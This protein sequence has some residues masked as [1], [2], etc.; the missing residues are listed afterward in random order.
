MPLHTMCSLTLTC[1]HA[2]SL[3]CML[4]CVQCMLTHTC[5]HDCSWTLSHACT[6]L[7][8]LTHA[9]TCSHMLTHTHTC[10]HMLTHAC[11]S[12]LLHSHVCIVCSHVCIVCSHVHTHTHTHLHTCSHTCLHTHSHTCL[13]KGSDANIAMV[14]V[15]QCH[16]CVWS[17]AQHASGMKVTHSLLLPTWLSAGASMWAQA[18]LCG[19]HPDSITH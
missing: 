7:H 1:T 17:A 8:T 14:C 3:T 18:L 10:L 15:L 16:G 19:L 11:M 2:H 12:T 6:H 13:H 5:Y 4:S 9:H